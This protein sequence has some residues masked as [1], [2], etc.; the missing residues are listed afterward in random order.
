M[1]AAPFHGSAPVMPK[2]SAAGGATTPCLTDP[3]LPATTS[4]RAGASWLQ[5][6]GNVSPQDAL[7]GPVA[8]GVG[9]GAGSAVA[10]AFQ[11]IGNLLPGTGVGALLGVGWWGVLRWREHVQASMEANK[12][13][14]DALEHYP[15]VHQ[16]LAAKGACMHDMAAVKQVSDFVDREVKRMCALFEQ[17]CRQQGLKVAPLM[18]AVLRHFF[19]LHCGDRGILVVSRASTQECYLVAAHR[20][21]QEPIRLA[22]G[23]KGASPTAVLRNLRC[24]YIRADLANERVHAAMAFQMERDDVEYI[25]AAGAGSGQAARPREPAAAHADAVA[26]RCRRP[27]SHRRPAPTE[28]PTGPGPRT[29]PPATCDIVRGQI[30]R[31]QMACLPASGRTLTK[32]AVIVEDLQAGRVCGKPVTLH[33]VHYSASDIQLDG[34]SGRNLWRL[35]HRRTPGGHELVGIV[36]YHEPRGGGCRMRWWEP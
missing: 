6:L 18:K 15:A 25:P 31:D 1:L 28:P 5:S 33:G 9:A 27:A 30:L 8:A 3:P 13:R 22:L 7:A 10:L 20:E 35:L 4:A 16:L 19:L 17:H 34:L 21:N 24:P 32:L 23:R 11:G 29:V 12:A 14:V 26:P 36:D 2:L